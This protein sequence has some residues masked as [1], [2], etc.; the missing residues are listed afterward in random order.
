MVV[1]HFVNEGRWAG[2]KGRRVERGQESFTAKT[3]TTTPHPILQAPLYPL[4]S[5]LS[6]TPASANPTKPKRP[7]CPNTLQTFPVQPLLKTDTM[8]P[9]EGDSPMHI[10]IPRIFPQLRTIAR[11]F[12]MSP[13]SNHEHLGPTMIAFR[14]IT[15]FFRKT[16]IAF[17]RKPHFHPSI[18]TKPRKKR[19][20]SH[21]HS[22]SPPLATISLSLPHA[23]SPRRPFSHSPAHPVPNVSPQPPLTHPPNCAKVH[24]FR[25]P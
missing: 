23:I 8:R 2:G 17:R 15:T 11:P 4:P 1:R 18:L 5:T 3:A 6:T 9:G 14:E 7:K 19:P 25:S 10:T 13:V 20:K 24:P 22:P 12:P 21:H 16:M